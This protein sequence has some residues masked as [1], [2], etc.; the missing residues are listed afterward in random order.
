MSDKLIQNIKKISIG[1]WSFG[2][3]R[4]AFYNTSLYDMNQKKILL[5]DKFANL[6]L[7]TLIAPIFFPI[8]MIHD[9]NILDQVL[10]KKSF[11]SSVFPL[12]GYYKHE[13]E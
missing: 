8:Y 10:D 9:L 7:G 13:P 3:L 12:Q 11:Y 2:F 1:L 6:M 5:G 4:S